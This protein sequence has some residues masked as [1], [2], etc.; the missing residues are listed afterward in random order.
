MTFST[1]CSFAT[2]LDKFT[3]HMPYA[4][5]TSCEGR[6]KLRITFPG[7]EILLSKHVIWSDLFPKLCFHY[8]DMDGGNGWF[9]WLKKVFK[10]YSRCCATIIALR[11]HWHLSS[12]RLAI[13]CTCLLLI[14]EAGDLN[15]HEN[16]RFLPSLSD[17]WKHRFGNKSDLVTFILR[18]YIV[19]LQGAYSRGPATAKQRWL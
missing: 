13:L 3:K 5:W 16:H 11:K 8:S 18:I 2:I 15:S 9:S 10:S 17:E 6:C 12:C 14:L 1:S 4:W 7:C 19:P